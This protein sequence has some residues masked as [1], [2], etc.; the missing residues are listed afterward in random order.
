MTGSPDGAVTGDRRPGQTLILPSEIAAQRRN[1]LAGVIYR[2]RT[3]R[4]AGVPRVPRNHYRTPCSH[5][6]VR[7]AHT[8]SGWKSGGVQP[9]RWSSP[10]MHHLVRRVQSRPG[11]PNRWAVPPRRAQGNAEPQGASGAR[12]SAAPPRSMAGQRMRP[13]P[14]HAVTS[15]T[16]RAGACSCVRGHLGE[17]LVDDAGRLTTCARRPS[18][19]HAV[20]SA[21]VTS[22]STPGR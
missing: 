3:D 9:N 11:F 10:V 15:T 2:T 1:P 4:L 19:P 22:P 16:G 13:P 17:R 7:R 5:R 18:N 6:H 14:S 21:S 8:R 20:T 12:P